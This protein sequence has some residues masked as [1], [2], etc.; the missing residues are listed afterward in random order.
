M[1]RYR[2]K[3]TNAPYNSEFGQL[4]TAKKLFDVYLTSLF[5]PG[6]FQFFELG[7]ASWVASEGRQKQKRKKLKKYEENK[8]CP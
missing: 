7:K 5:Y 2:V 8:N 6:S 3:Q 4:S 1:K